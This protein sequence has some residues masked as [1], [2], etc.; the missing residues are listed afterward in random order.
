MSAVDVSTVAVG[1]EVPAL[2]V[3]ITQTDMVAYAGATWD[4]H[5]MHYDPA[6]V[7]E[8]KFPAAVVDGQVYGA[9][10]VQQLQDWL[11]PKA[12]V[13]A[14]EFRFKNLVFAGDTLRC[15]ATVTAVRPTD[16][17]VEIDV[18]SQ[19]EVTGDKARV[20]AAPCSATVIVR[21]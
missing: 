12:W 21:A 18:E 11:G 20:A 14:L 5:R 19:I 15:T 4:W 16:A 2:E 13:S 3:T 1:T 6:F 17:G 8:K 7:A 10:L 9:Y